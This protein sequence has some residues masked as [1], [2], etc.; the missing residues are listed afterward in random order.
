MSSKK[1]LQTSETETM[2]TPKKESNDYAADWNRKSPDKIVN[3]AVNSLE[4]ALKKRL[5][6]IDRPKI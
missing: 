5:N 1:S 2:T 3:D 4:R 6:M